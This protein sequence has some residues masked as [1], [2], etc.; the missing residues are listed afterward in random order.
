MLRI[1]RRLRPD[2]PWCR[3]GEGAGKTLGPALRADDLLC[4]VRVANLQSSSNRD[5]KQTSTVLPQAWRS[6]VD[7]G[8]GYV[9]TLRGW[10]AIERAVGATRV[11]IFPEL[12]Q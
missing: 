8:Y 5:V 3:R 4:C 9:G 1:S 12:A 6:N 11:V 10:R 2:E 7:D